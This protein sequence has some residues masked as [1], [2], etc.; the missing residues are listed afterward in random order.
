MARS[1]QGGSTHEPIGPASP[2]NGRG[3]VDL[4][5]QPGPGAQRRSIESTA[6]E[7]MAQTPASDVVASGPPPGRPAVDRSNGAEPKIV[8]TASAAR[9][10]GAT[11]AEPMP[12]EAPEIDI[13]LVPD[14]DAVGFRCHIDQVAD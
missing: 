7:T 2:S 8:A 3:G 5:A 14:T 1:S 11:A 10:D 13:P 9:Q 4:S 12:A 6:A